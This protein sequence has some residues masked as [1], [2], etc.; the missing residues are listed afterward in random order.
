MYEVPNDMSPDKINGV[1][2]LIN[3]PNYNLWQTSHFSTDSIHSVYNR[4]ESVSYLELKIWYKYL[5]KL[6]RRI[7]LMVLRKKLKNGNLLS[8]HVEFARFFLTNLGFV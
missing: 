5:L 8:V 4:T 2:K 1:F 3:T 6:K 7:P